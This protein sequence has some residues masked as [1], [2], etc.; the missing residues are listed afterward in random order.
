MSAA[1][2]SALIG[3]V[4]DKAEKFIAE[5]EYTGKATWV[6]SSF[7]HHPVSIANKELQA[8]VRAYRKALER[9]GGRG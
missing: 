1:E 5:E 8:A 9:K 2:L 3:R 7:P 6:M 4:V